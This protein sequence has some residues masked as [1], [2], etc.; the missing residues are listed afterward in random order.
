MR[1]RE[2]KGE[3]ISCIAPHCQSVV[4]RWLG[5]GAWQDE[6]LQEVHRQLRE[7]E[8]GNSDMQERWNLQDFKYHLLIDMVSSSYPPAPPPLPTPCAGRA[9]TEGWRTERVKGGA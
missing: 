9:S 2:R 3:S 6:R 1:E 4:Q 7:R 8:M 5:L